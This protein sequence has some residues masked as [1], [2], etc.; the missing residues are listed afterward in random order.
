MTYGEVQDG[1]GSSDLSD[2]V[3]IFHRRNLWD[4][5]GTFAIGDKTI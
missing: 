2:G 3:G 4:N 1:S 5:V